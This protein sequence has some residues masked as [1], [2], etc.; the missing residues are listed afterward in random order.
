MTAIMG[1]FTVFA[2]GKALA[3][4]RR[5][6]TTGREALIGS[7]ATVRSAFDEQGRG[8]VHTAG[9]TWNATIASGSP[10]PAVGDRV[11]I[12]SRQGYTLVVRKVS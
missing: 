10:I 3:A 7:I 4:Q 12:E 9:E 5:K 8:A 2:G 1:G 6:P 11:K